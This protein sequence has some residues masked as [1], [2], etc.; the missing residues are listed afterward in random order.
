M[1]L[2]INGEKREVAAGTV[3]EVTK[4]LG[5]E[6]DYFAVALNMNCVPRSRHAETPVKDGDAVEILTPMQ[7]G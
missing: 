5:Y 6:G 4:A 3:A 2:T 7:G 1:K